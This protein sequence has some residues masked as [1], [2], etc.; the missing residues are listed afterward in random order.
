M[1]QS[2]CNGLCSL[3][4]SKQGS[5]RT[6]LRSPNTGAYVELRGQNKYASLL[7]TCQRATI[8]FHNSGTTTLSVRVN[9]GEA[10]PRLLGPSDGL[11]QMKV[12]GN[13]GSVRWTVESA[14]STLFYG[15]AMDGT[16]GIVLDNFSLRG[17]SGLSLRSVPVWMMR[18][19]NEQRPYDLIILQYG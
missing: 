5:I 10:T 18:E 15:L 16:S 4:D 3:T 2:F 14:D 19:F 13:I 7:D 9:H 6:L 1:V 12:E 11:Q 17:S 8:F